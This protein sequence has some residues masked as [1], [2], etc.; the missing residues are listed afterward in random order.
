MADY[1]GIGYLRTKL[2]QKRTRVLMRYRYYEMKNAVRD[3]GLVTPPAF[4]A[5]SET[6]G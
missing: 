2:V 3:F 4:R 5:F 6:L 1:K